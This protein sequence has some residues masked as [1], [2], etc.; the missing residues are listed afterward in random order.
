MLGFT[1]IYIFLAA[2]LTLFSIGEAIS[3]SNHSYFV[4]NQTPIGHR[5]RFS[6][7]RTILEEA[8]FAIGPLLGGKI[9]DN[10]GYPTI[11]IISSL[12]LTIFFIGLEI[13]RILYKKNMEQNIKIL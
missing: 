3:A 5:A 4:T 8:G 11:F 10:F 12:I 9:I 1:T 6:S 13:I 7:I 2:L